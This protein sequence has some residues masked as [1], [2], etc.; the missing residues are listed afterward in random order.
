M[1]NN[2]ADHRAAI[3]SDQHYMMGTPHADRPRGNDSRA[4]RPIGIEEINAA[5]KAKAKR[6]AK[7]KM[8][9]QSRKKK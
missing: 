3:L 7:K 9:Q 6:K 2:L 5:N 4:P 8:R 1:K